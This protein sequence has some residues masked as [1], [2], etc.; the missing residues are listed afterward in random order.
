MCQRSTK[1]ARRRPV[2]PRSNLVLLTPPSTAPPAH[3]LLDR[4][5]F[6][7][8]RRARGRMLAGRCWIT[9]PV[10]LAQLSEQPI[11]KGRHARKWPTRASDA[12]SGHD[13]ARLPLCAS[14]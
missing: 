13:H 7:E 3:L 6:G 9:A 4:P 11:G 10:N 5:S 2:D 8:D 12:S 1:R 14:L